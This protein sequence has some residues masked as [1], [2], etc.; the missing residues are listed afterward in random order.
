[1]NGIF[2][3]SISVSIEHSVIVNLMHDSKDEFS[4]QFLDLGFI[5]FIVEH[6][7]SQIYILPNY[8]K[9]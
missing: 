6:V 9:T 7:D 2:S 1:M 5:K 8:E 4:I 3:I